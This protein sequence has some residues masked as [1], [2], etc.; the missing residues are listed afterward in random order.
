MH[1]RL[2]V[3]ALTAALAPLF[4]HAQQQTY[5]DV[6]FSGF[7]T[8]GI[9]RTDNDAAR[10][11]TSVLQPDGATTTWDLRPDSVL[12]GQVNARFTRDLSAVLQVVA[13]QSAQNDFMPH[14]EWA[15]ARYALTPDLSARA[16]IMAAPIYMLSD[17]RLVGISFPWVR[18]P[19]AFYQQTPITNFRGVDLVYRKAVGNAAFTLQPYF[20]KAPTDVPT[21]VN[22]SLKA[23]LDRAMGI[24][25]KAEWGDW[26]VR[27]AYFQT[28][29]SYTGSSIPD[30][31]AGLNSVAPYLPGAAELA[32]QVD[33]TD[34]RLS[35]ATVGVSYDSGP[36]FAQAE[37][38]K[39]RSKTL[40]LAE[41]SAWYAT[42]GY[43][44]GNVMP[45]ITYSEA[46][47]DSPLTQDVVPPVEPFGDLAAGLNTLLVSSNTA[48]KT[49]A[50]GARWQFHRNADLKVQWD[51][52]KLPNGAVGNFN[53]NVPIASPVNV[54]S[55]AVDFVF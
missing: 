28:D 22:Q 47:V 30:L 54:Y 40:L 21:G 25:A 44:F 46:K 23:D 32:Q 24:S 53:S 38:G 50:L 13:N 43:R 11:V 8:L 27:A 12:A 55:V 52:V 26:T 36:I 2:R 17:S 19:T 48:M 33:A 3:A 41:T 20:G 49:V 29:F 34:K 7:G 5:P 42:F 15:F 18:P 16:G 1:H 4:L 14:V 31:V 9:A 35:F 51:R 6:S 39:R 10:F 37:Y 45:H